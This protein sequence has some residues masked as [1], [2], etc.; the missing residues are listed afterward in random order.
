MDS[1]LRNRKTWLRVPFNKSLV[2]GR[3]NAKNPDR[4]TVQDLPPRLDRFLVA[5]TGAK[6]QT[7]PYIEHVKG[8]ET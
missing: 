4:V 6:K 2:A 5:Y 1:L 7:C 3:F 8:L